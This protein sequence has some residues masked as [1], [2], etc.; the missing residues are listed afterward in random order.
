[1][2]LTI[3][4]AAQR[5]GVSSATIRRRIHKGIVKARK[6]DTPQGYRWIVELSDEEPETAPTKAGGSEIVAL[7]A[8]NDRL[9][10]VLEEIR[11]ERDY[12]RQAHAAALSTIR[13]LAPPVQERAEP[14]P[15]SME[16]VIEAEKPAP[17]RQ[18]LWGKIREW[19]SQ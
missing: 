19:W 16:T 18:S 17:A 3:Q 15:E 8:E 13:Q 7:Q 11:G 1:M 5:L 4:E 2:D 10:A 6:E 14:E 12:L 9:M